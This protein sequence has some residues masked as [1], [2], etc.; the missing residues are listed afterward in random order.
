MGKIS[1]A[2]DKYREQKQQSD[3]VTAMDSTTVSE[4]PPPV[5]HSRKTDSNFDSYEDILTRL[6]TRY[7]GESIK[8][9]MFTSTVH[10][11][12]ATTTAINFAKTLVRDSHVKVLLMD[13]NLRTPNLGRIFNINKNQGL[14]D[15]VFE[16][17]YKA[18]KVIKYGKSHLFVLASG[19][20][21]TGPVS[22]FES[23]RFDA[24]L[25]KARKWFDYVIMDSA[26]LPSFAESRTLCEKVDGV[27]MVLESGKVR[28]HVA[29]RAKKELEDAGARI[30]GVVLN[31]RKYYIPDWVYK[32]L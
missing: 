32:R 13:G 16:N 12:G 26:P 2:L 3:L 1:N 23:K 25:N 24:F 21:H 17:D 29:L 18:F 22:L 4:A 28:Q 15:I 5:Q 8:S 6:H 9:I 19:G 10:G 31:R 30:L 27:V 11:G 14:S 20:N 7:P